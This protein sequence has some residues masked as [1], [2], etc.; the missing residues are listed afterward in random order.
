MK[1]YELTYLISPE[2]SEEEIKIISQ[3][4]SDFIYEEGGTVENINP[5]I[6]KKLGYL[7]KKKGFAYLSV[8]N[9]NL[10]PEKPLNLEKKLKAEPEILRYQILVKKLPRKVISA[11]K[12][13]HLPS[14]VLPDKSKKDKSAKVELEEIEKK[15]EEILEE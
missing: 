7:I 6:Q 5:P 9:L 13:P 4:V 11:V 15:L 8:L 14:Q 2:I 10:E 3:K 12:P 1:S